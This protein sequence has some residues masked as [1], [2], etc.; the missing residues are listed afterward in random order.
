MKEK[1]WLL[2]SVILGT[3]LLVS[4]FAIW[5]GSPSSLRSSGQG[6]A[7]SGQNLGMQAVSPEKIYPLFTCPC[8]GKPLDKN[9]ICC[10]MARERINYIDSLVAEGKSEKEIVLAYVKK[11]GFTSF[12]DKNREEEF[13]KELVKTAPTN[14]PVIVLT[15]QT[16]DFGA[17][18]QKKGKVSTTFDLKNEGKS[19]LVI[20]KLDTSCGCTSASIVY[21]GKEGPLFAMEGH[22]AKNPTDWSLTIPAGETAQLKV[23]YDPD[24]HKDFRGPATR[25]ISVFSND[26]VDFEKKVLIELNQ[27]D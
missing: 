9:N 21:Q 22:G 13:K 24:V 3:L 4:L 7:K 14:R 10:E 2:T 11:Y 5:Q 18:S 26:P 8:C 16:Y 17:V 19:D 20:N 25:E 15:P 1:F 12:A 27:V 23:Y 6:A